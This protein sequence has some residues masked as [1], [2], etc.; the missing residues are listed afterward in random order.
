M[1][2]NIRIEND[3]LTTGFFA[4]TKRGTKVHVVNIDGKPICNSKI[5]K[6]MEYQWCSTSVYFPYIECEKCKK[7][8]KKKNE[9]KN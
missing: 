4:N 5:G 1:K 6:N 3:R 8:I 2:K 9:S 7:I